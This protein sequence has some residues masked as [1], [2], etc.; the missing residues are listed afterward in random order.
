[1][2]KILNIIKK[3]EILATG[4]VKINNKRDNYLIYSDKVTYLKI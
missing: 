4:N 1:M 2:P 3:N